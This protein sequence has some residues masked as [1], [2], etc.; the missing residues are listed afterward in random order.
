MKHLNN[1]TSLPLVPI[2]VSGSFLLDNQL[3]TR[4]AVDSKLTTA[5]SVPINHL[6]KKKINPPSPIYA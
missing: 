4:K 3:L 5:S 2:E 1:K 6:R